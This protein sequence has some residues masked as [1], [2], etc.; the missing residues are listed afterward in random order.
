MHANTGVTLLRPL[1]LPLHV[2]RYKAVN[3]LARQLGV[4]QLRKLASM[5]DFSYLNQALIGNKLKVNRCSIWGKG[6]LTGKGMSY[7]MQPMG[8]PGT[9]GLL[10]AVVWW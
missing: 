3:F 9:L 6:E 7:T 4:V 5:K 2:R 1:R 10:G 8:F